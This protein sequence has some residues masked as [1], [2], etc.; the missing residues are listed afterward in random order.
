MKR[1]RPYSRASR[2]SDTASV[3][4]HHQRPCA[5]AVDCAQ[6][7]QSA[8]HSAAR[9]GAPF[10][11]RNAAQ[12]AALA[13]AA[14]QTQDRALQAT[15]PHGVA[16]HHA[17]MEPEDR[18][19][20]EQLFL[21]RHVMFLAATATLAQV[22]QCCLRHWRSCLVQRSSL[23]LLRGVVCAP[24]RAL[25]RC[26]RGV[27]GARWRFRVAWH[28][29]KGPHLWPQGTRAAA[30]RQPAGAPRHH[31]GHTALRRRWL[32][33]VRARRVPADDW[34]RG[35]ADAPRQP[36]PR[37]PSTSLTRCLTV[38]SPSFTSYR[39]ALSVILHTCR[40]LQAGGCIAQGGRSLTPP[41]W[42]SS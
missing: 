23:L 7:V 31:Q 6:K 10:F 24:P 30:G 41:R 16:W 34:P 26:A 3:M 38:D 37:P 12:A 2:I 39:L 15:L 22:W 9:D 20:V 27:R 28:L 14:A 21:A 5:G 35:C 17:A 4:R 29:H 25:R 33:G 36:P 32:P 19:L 11:V 18:A 8:A 42:P 1:V 40:R 13:G